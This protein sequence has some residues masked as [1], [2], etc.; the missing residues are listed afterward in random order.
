M[1]FKNN[2]WIK[3]LMKKCPL[4]LA[5]VKS[6]V[7]RSEAEGKRINQQGGVDCTNFLGLIHF[8]RVGKKNVRKLLLFGKIL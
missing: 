2:F 1:K 3:V 7:T 6:G 8:I 4:E 5:L